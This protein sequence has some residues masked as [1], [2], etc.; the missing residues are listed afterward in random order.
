MS[1][2]LWFFLY[3]TQANTQQVLPV[4]TSLNRYDEWMVQEIDD[5]THNGS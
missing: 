4:Q 5:E 1:S 3:K 2:F